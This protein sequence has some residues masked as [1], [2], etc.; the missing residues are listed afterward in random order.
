MQSNSKPKRVLIWA[1]TSTKEQS[2]KEQ[3]EDLRDFIDRRE[4]W[5]EVECL[6]LQGISGTDKKKLD[7]YNNILLEMA[8]KKEFDVMLVKSID[9]ITRGNTDDLFLLWKRLLKKGVQIY[10]YLER[11]TDEIED[12]NL[13]QV[14]YAMENFRS[15]KQREN[16]SEKTKLGLAKTNKKGGRPKGS[17]DKKT[18]KKKGY[19]G[20]QNY[21]GGTLRINTT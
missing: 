1:R 9:R 20:N 4:D 19:I 7:E 13:K 5:V 11:F 3:I 14:V 18:R 12:D 2:T 15:I 16:I 10:S 6:D 17:K 8:H 21:K